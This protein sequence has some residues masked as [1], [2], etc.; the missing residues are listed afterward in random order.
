MSRQRIP[1]VNFYD[2]QNIDETDMD[3]EQ[4]AWHTSVSSAVDFL[5]GSGVE[6]EYT[7]QRVLFDSDSVPSSIQGL[8]DTENF[9]GEP[10][11]EED[12]FDNTIFL[13]PQDAVEGNQLE[14]TISGGNLVGSIVSRV[15]IF[16]TAL[17][18]KY[19]QEVLTFEDN[20][21]LLT[22]TYFTKITA[23]MTQNMFG[24]QNTII[25]GIKSKNI[26]GRLVVKEA[27]SMTLAHDTVMASQDLEPNINYIDFKTATPSKSLDTILDEISNS[28]GF[29]TDD[30]YI[31]TT[32]TSTRSLPKNDSSGT[33]IGQ[34]FKAS[35]NNVQK[36]SLLL[37]V[38]ENTL[39]LPGEEF[40]WS[41]DVVVGIRELQTNTMCPTDTLPSN[42][43][44][45]D[46]QPSPLAEVS[47]DMSQLA[48]MGVVLT[49]KPQ[50]VDFVFT[51]S[52]LANPN[53]APDITAGAYY[54]LTV[55]RSGNVSSGTIILQ[56]AAN[57]NRDVSI[58]DDMRM[59][60][61]SQNKWTD[62]PESDMWFIIYTDAVRITN[63]T[64]F[65]G[66]VQITSPKTIKNEITGIDE[67]YI[68][69]K[70]S[71]IDV[72]STGDNYVVV[73]K[74][75]NFS[76]AEV[77][78]ST[79]NPVFSRI[80]DV[81][82]I[83]IVS[84]DTL[85]TLIESGSEPIVLGSV[86]DTNPVSNP[87]ISG[88]SDFPGLATQNT[89]T[90][91][92]PNSDITL[93]NLVGSI[94]TPNT[95]ESELRYR[96][97]QVD[98]YEDA[99]GDINGDGVIDIHDVAMAQWLDGYSKD[100]ES[101]SLASAD[102]RNAI[103]NGTVTMAQ[104]IRADVNN[105]IIINALDTQS[106]QQNISLGSSFDAGGSFKR[107]VITVESLVNPLTTS[108]NISGSDPS[109]NTVPFSSVPYDIEFVP[110]WKENNLIITDLR[111]FVPKTFTVL[112]TSNI[113][114]DTQSGGT[115]TLFVPG[116]I[117]LGGELLNIDGST[118]SIDFEVNSIVIDLPDGSTQGEVDIFS[119]FI[120]NKMKFSDET[121]VPQDAL[122]DNQVKVTAAI[123]S[124]TKDRD[125]YDFES[126][127]GYAAIHETVSVL[128]T[129]SS[130][131]LRVRANNIRYIDTRPELR[132]K[133]L[134]T[135]YLK[136]SGFKNSETSV[137]PTDFSELLTTI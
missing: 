105:D 114:G 82:S 94:L 69:G 73:Q 46:P 113:T 10:I 33:I 66:G 15:Y 88:A 111:R 83:E 136:K 9:D 110:I 45:F 54:V 61:F 65:D 123:M 60:V 134:L 7:T 57:T 124:F 104:I 32:A 106:I 86:K 47:F 34:K 76:D 98:I 131:L 71:L 29:N 112:D 100:L 23:L 129:Q 44:D 56:E 130:G 127:D 116:D 132:T 11:Y 121:L 84:K 55:R 3:V 20:G 24:N 25:D 39:A 27:L 133:I 135:V 67:P 108:P 96:I 103:I 19:T 109:F 12:S 68:N 93:N 99:Y 48:N 59:T 22:R 41:G 115:N 2:G 118:Y 87:S 35:T 36:V 16:G 89:F 42:Y 31:N 137:S 128:Y 102:Q 107:A 85:L 78:P 43:I 30:L 81:P 126:I 70:F 125:G 120:K 97:V 26:N 17:G 95:N 38:E 8:I 101:G 51:Q 77:H 14:V 64:A 72:S 37:S 6:Q 50:V 63:G 21:S 58:E 80:E 40:N 28:A 79:G 91:I 92:Q 13:Q 75:Q 53:I 4:S 117:I 74:S 122:D 18:E 62:I 49:D 119:N 5:A 52:L 90:I 1:R